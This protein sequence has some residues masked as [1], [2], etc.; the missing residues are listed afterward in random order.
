MEK[1]Q[2]RQEIDAEQ[3][4]RESERQ[5]EERAQEEEKRRMEEEARR[6]EEEEY[7]AIKGMFVTET[8]GSQATDI[9]TESQ[10]LLSEF[11]EFIAKRKVLSL[12]D[13]ATH[14]DMKTQEAVNRVNALEEMG[15]LTG[16]TD[17]RGKYIFIEKKV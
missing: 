8:E 17:D 9:T 15:L 7:Q 13:L 12:E 2:I 1:Q 5:E 4:R 11:V 16:V 14:F 10:S 6:K 3:E